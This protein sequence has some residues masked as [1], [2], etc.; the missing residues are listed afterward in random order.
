MENKKVMKATPTNPEV[1]NFSVSMPTGLL[2]KLDGVR[3]FV[4]RSKCIE[5]AVEH[6]L[7]TRTGLRGSSIGGS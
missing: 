5:L 4:P 2:H 1:T 6:W 3:G 7:K